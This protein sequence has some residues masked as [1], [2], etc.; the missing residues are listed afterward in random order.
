MILKGLDLEIKRGEKIALLGDNGSGKS[1][2]IKLMLGLYKPLTGTIRINGIDLN[3]LDLNSWRARTTAIFQDFQK[4][5]LLNVRENVAVGQIEHL[6]DK[7]LARKAAL[8]SG[9]DAMIQT[10]SEGYETLLGKEFGGT[11]L[12]KGQWQKLAVARAY[13]RDSELLILDEP[14]ASLDAKAEVE[15]YRQFEQVS[16]GKTVVFISHR[17]GAAKLADRIIVLNNGHIEEQG[18]HA[19][20]LKQNGQYAHMYQLQARWYL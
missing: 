11:E 8:R 16:L 19:E 7:E 5:Q 17:L 13:F 4:Y 10:L 2:L 9:A 1:T 15:I 18:T 14:T 20:L 6:N 12:S 3:E